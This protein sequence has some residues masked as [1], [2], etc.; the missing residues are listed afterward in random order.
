MNN[1]PEATVVLLTFEYVFSMLNSMGAGMLVVGSVTVVVDS[2]GGSAAVCR[3]LETDRQS[4]DLGR[5]ISKEN[6][7]QKIG[8]LKVTCVI[9]LLFTKLCAIKCREARYAHCT[10]KNVCNNAVAHINVC[11]S[12]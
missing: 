4:R 3:C 5:L 9:T 6:K 1:L 2:P 12:I 10:I 7:T 11:N 8:K